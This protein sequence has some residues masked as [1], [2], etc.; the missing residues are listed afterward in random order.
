[1]PTKC[2]YYLNE[3]TN[4]YSKDVKFVEKF[5]YTSAWEAINALGEWQEKHPEHT[6]ILTVNVEVIS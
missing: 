1:M 3:C 4:L 6:F 2:T 5:S